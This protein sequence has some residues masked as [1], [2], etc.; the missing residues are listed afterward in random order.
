PAA[1]SL[2]DL[3]PTVGGEAPGAGA[4]RYRDERLTYRDWDLLA[5]RL[6][7]ALRAHG[8]DRGSVV[9]LL[10]PS[11]PLYL[12]GYL[13]AAGLGAVTTGL[14]VRYRRSEIR[15]VLRRAAAPLL[16]AVDRW[17]EVDFRPII[18]P[19]R[20]ELPELA[21]VLLPDADELR[22]STA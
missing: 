3:L 22:Q 5:D 13:A 7:A 15:R 12:V 21:R 17:H 20:D 16:L 1:R 14:N 18:E 2:L 4:F 10:L 19:V 9:A 8:V 6:A 11:T